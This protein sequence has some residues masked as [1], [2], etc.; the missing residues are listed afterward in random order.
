MAAVSIT[1]GSVIPSSSAVVV[2][3]T[4]GAA[5]N[6]GQL[7][8]IDTANSNVLKL[9]DNDASALASTVAGIARNTAAT[10][11]KCFYITQDPALVLGC[12]MVVGDTLWSSPTAGGI[13]ITAADNVTGCFVTVVGVCTVVNSTVNFKILPAGAI[14]A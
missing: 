5:I 11:Q 9:A 3:G 8:Y 10:G 1:A 14:K 2:E 6:A 4:A 7:V 12:T 13:T